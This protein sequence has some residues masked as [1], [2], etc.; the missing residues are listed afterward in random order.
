MRHIGLNMDTVKR[1]NRSSILRLINNEGPIS[2]K[3]IAVRLSLT[4]A[5]VTQICSEF[6]ESGLLVERGVGDEEVIRAGR[7]KVLIDIAPEYCY[8]YGI[9]IE[10]EYTRM[11]I[12]N[13]KGEALACTEMKTRRGEAPESF[14]MDVGAAC[15]TLRR[16]CKI[17]KEKL[18]GAGVGITGIV[19]KQKAQSLHAYGIWEKPVEVGTILE[20]CLQLPV[21]L[22]NNVNAFAEAELI[23]GMGRQYDDL[24]LVKWGPGVGSSVIIDNRIYEGTC[25]KAAELGHFIV[26]KDGALCSCGRHGCLETKVAVAALQRELPGFPEYIE[27]E[28]AVPL[29]EAVDLLARSIVNAATILAPEKIVLYGSVL[30]NERI[31]RMLKCACEH[32]DEAFVGERICCSTLAKMEGYIGP[33]AYFINEQIFT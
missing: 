18:A 3:D 2:K 26:D 19:D 13:L 25:G 9:N 22:E 7:K 1:S 33:V 21:R 28:R 17:A 11:A 30:H 8:L 32:Y 29:T 15:E 14:L 24:L 16:D 5:A 4:P 10:P 12:C 31:Y 23:F 6:M 20:N 27:D